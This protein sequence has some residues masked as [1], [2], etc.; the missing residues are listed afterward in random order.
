MPRA[1]GIGRVE[2]EILRYISDHHP[3]TVRE[4]GEH[5]AREKGHT[6][7]TALNIMERLREKGY[8]TRTK[9]EGVFQYSPSQ[10]RS[11]L[12]TGIVRDFVDGMLGGSL[13]PFV[14]YLTRQEDLTPEQIQELRDLLD[15]VE[16]KQQ[17]EQS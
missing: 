2:A 11:Q 1:T 8:L 6:R 16:A 7:T 15:R 9:V 13:D 4:V 12:M 14:S 5:L 10:S 17:E 3:I